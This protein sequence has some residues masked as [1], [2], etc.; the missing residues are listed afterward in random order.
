MI[1]PSP[2]HACPNCGSA[3]P[4]GVPAGQCPRCLMAQILDPTQGG[5]NAPPIPPLTPEEIA[6]HFPQ[7]EILECLGRGGMGVVY[8]ARQKT[9]NRLVALKL[10]APERAD[11]PQFAAR[12]EKEAQA[13]AALNHPHI[14]G[15]HDFGQAGGFY[16]LLMEFVDGVNLRQL[17]QTKRLTPQE[18][19]SIVPPVCEALQCAHEHGIV[20]RD[21]KPENLLIDKSGVVKIADFGIAK[22]YSGHLTPHTEQGAPHH[23]AATLP[24]GTPDYAAPE[25]A[26]GAADHRADIYS[27]GVVLYEML[28]GERPKDKIEAPSKR[29]QVDIRID[30]IV[31]RALEKAPELRFATAAEFRTQVEN[32]GRSPARAGRD[33]GL[34][35]LAGGIFA[36]LILSLWTV[37]TLVDSPV[38]FGIME[39]LILIAASFGWARWR[40]RRHHVIADGW[41]TAPRGT[42]PAVARSKLFRWAGVLALIAGFGLLFGSSAINELVDDFGL[43]Q[44]ARKHIQTRN[45]VSQA[46]DE[47]K[48]A[49]TDAA[50]RRDEAKK[51]S[52]SGGEI[53]RLSREAEK[54]HL[55]A[56][57]AEAR[58]NQ[59][60]VQKQADE[61]HRKA[62]LYFISGILI[63]GGV[64][65]IFVNR[66]IIK[67]APGMQYSGMPLK[68]AVHR[69][70]LLLQ[71]LAVLVG[72]A[73]MVSAG[74]RM[75]EP[76]SNAV[77]RCTAKLLHQ[78]HPPSA[79]PLSKRQ[80]ELADPVAQALLVLA[81]REMARRADLRARSFF[82]QVQDAEIKMHAR[83]TSQS[84]VIEIEVTGASQDFIRVYCNAVVD[85]FMAAE[86]EEGRS[87]FAIVQRATWPEMAPAPRWTIWPWR[88]E[89]D[90]N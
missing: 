28:T 36:V 75:R 41:N 83:G 31:L 86:A 67:A 24:F 63:V 56:V 60:A 79:D 54:L 66:K 8:K 59:A 80:G 17:L 16:Y 55:L 21:I 3:L 26:S 82:S 22:M 77:F 23:A 11:D 27:L 73:V 25:Q 15:V 12:F 50:L 4:A 39:I 47:A 10:L 34:W 1:D 46:W 7:L 29:V 68:S 30:E 2:T 48:I 88:A 51:A 18:A 45:R 20:H 71:A 37:L 33:A 87:N 65:T 6:P 61:Q 52:K 40:I 84:P 81:G 72:L 64:A 57:Q 44:G 38:S 49:A 19:L 43:T 74:S 32:L 76:T 14:V 89:K 90:M 58:V 42:L 5:E 13:L 70:C 78:N 35:W 85:E 53:E 69:I 9:L 62:M